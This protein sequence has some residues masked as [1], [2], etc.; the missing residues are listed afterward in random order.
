MPLF[1]ILLPT[2]AASYGLQSVMAVIFV[3]QANEK[4]YDLGGALG[5]MTST[6]VSLYYPS[7]KARYW[8]RLPGVQLP[9]ITSFSPRQLLLSAAVV[10]WSTRLGSFLV[11]RAFKA[12]GDSRFDE[13]K[14]QPAKFTAFWMAQATW[15]F[16]VGLPVYLVNTLPAAAHPPLRPLDYLS[17]AL[18]TGSWIF[19]ILADRQKTEWRRARDN[20]EHDEKFITGGL[21]SVSRHPN[22]VGEVGLWTAMWLLSVTSLRTPSFPRASWLLAGASPLMT[23]FLLRNVSGVPPLERA[24][25]LR[26]GNDAKWREYKRTVPVFWPWGM[27]G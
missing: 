12:G 6:L 14:N 4:Y 23:W 26:F 19:E 20:K 25:D 17:V 15:V 11:T 24:G 5:F 3:P 7:L 16:I 18:F 21:W 2:A 1:S 13:V 22:Y 8:Y 27:R 10:A 9:P